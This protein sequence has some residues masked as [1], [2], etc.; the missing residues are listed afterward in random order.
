MVLTSGFHLYNS[1]MVTALHCVNVITISNF[2]A[3]LYVQNLHSLQIS[4]LMYHLVHWLYSSDHLKSTHKIVHV[5]ITCMLVW[6]HW[7]ALFLFALLSFVNH[8]S[9]C[10]WSRWVWSQPSISLFAC[11]GCFEWSLIFLS[12]SFLVSFCLNFTHH[13]FKITHRTCLYRLHK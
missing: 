4:E 7:L 11:P 9:L 5:N 3:S 13:Y 12:V 1:C 2:Y 8:Q 10:G 6:Q